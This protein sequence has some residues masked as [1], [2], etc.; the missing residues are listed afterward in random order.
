[1]SKK[2]NSGHGRGIRRYQLCL[3]AAA[4]AVMLCFS[5]MG[6]RGF[7][8]FGAEAGRVAPTV[9]T[10]ADVPRPVT[11]RTPAAAKAGD[12][13]QVVRFTIYDAGLYPRE[14]HAQAGRVIVSLTDYTGESAGLVVEREVPGGGRPET[15]GQAERAGARWRGRRE[16]RLGPGR[17]RVYDAS[18]PQ[19]FAALTVE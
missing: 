9:V 15:A 17:Y 2:D 8:S 3:A 7:A 11:G 1:M 6:R 5:V 10:P 18:R 19:N 12:A 4:A 13:V 14:A 16:M